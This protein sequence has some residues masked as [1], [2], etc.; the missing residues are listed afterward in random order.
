M[1]VLRILLEGME[2]SMDGVVKYVRELFLS[3]FLN[4]DL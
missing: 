3:V 1:N 4:Y 2:C